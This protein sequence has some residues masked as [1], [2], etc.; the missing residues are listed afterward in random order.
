VDCWISFF[1]YSRY[2]AGIL[3]R[4]C[5]ATLVECNRTNVPT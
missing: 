3:G 5:I 2:Q 4:Y 1:G